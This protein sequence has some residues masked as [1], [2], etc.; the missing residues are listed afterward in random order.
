MIFTVKKLCF[1]EYFSVFLSLFFIGLI[2][3]APAVCAYGAKCG[4]KISANV[5]V[6]SLFPFAIPVVFLINTPLYQNSKY[7]LQILFVF[8][9]IGGYPIGAKLISELYKGGSLSKNTAIK[10]LPFCVNAGPAFIVIAVGKGILCSVTVGYILLFS[11]T[12][13]S[14]IIALLFLKKELTNFNCIKVN[15]SSFSVC[16]SIVS[17]V[18]T[19]S[20][21]TISISAFVIAFSVINEYI[22]YYS[23][24][25]KPLKYLLYFME[26]TS[27]VAKTKNIYFIS[28]LLGFAGLSIWMQVYSVAGELKAPFI[29][30]AAVRILHGILSTIITAVV[31]KT[32]KIC[33]NTISNGKTIL[34]E[35]F[36]S[37]Y[38]LALSLFIMTL[39]LLINLTSKKH[40]GNLLKDV[41]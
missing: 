11:H 3:S 28:F 15:K 25:I 20:A 8:S 5:L 6:P 24:A 7:R 14:V 30:F 31:F 17:S 13:A 12:L 18:H 9:L 23:A 19:A 4:L 36:Y 16:D 1:L 26:V 39:L 2:L 29:K 41:V 38:A 32:F 27:A 37:D 35:A 33:V 34:G 22:T 21:A 10:M 40:S